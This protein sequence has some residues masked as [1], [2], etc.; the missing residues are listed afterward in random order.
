[1]TTIIVPDKERYHRLFYPPQVED[2]D[3]LLYDESTNTASNPVMGSYFVRT[4]PEDWTRLGSPGNKLIGRHVRLTGADQTEQAQSLDFSF[5][6]SLSPELAWQSFGRP[7]W[8]GNKDTQTDPRP[9]SLGSRYLLWMN[10]A[11]G[12]TGGQKITGDANGLAAGLATQAATGW[13]AS[14][15]AV[16]GFTFLRSTFTTGIM[17]AIRGVA[18]TSL[19]SGGLV[20]A[21][22][23]GGGIILTYLATTIIAG[24]FDN[25][26]WPAKLNAV[27]GWLASNQNTMT[28]NRRAL[29]IKATKIYNPG[30]SL[31]AVQEAELGDIPDGSVDA[32]ADTWTDTQR[33]AIIK[34]LFAWLAWSGDD[35]P[36]VLSERLTYAENNPD[37]FP[38]PAV[39]GELPSVEPIEGTATVLP[40]AITFGQRD[41]AGAS[42]GYE[43][44]L[45]Q[46]KVRVYFRSDAV[47]PGSVNTFAAWTRLGNFTMHVGS[48]HDSGG[49][50]TYGFQGTTLFFAR[51]AFSNLL[52]EGDDPIPPEIENGLVVFRQPQQH[53]PHGVAFLAIQVQGDWANRTA[54]RLTFRERGGQ[55]RQLIQLFY[56]F[57]GA[58]NRV[59]HAGKTYQLY[60]QI[61]PNVSLI[62]QFAKPWWASPTLLVDVTI[63]GTSFASPEDLTIQW[64]DLTDFFRLYDAGDNLL[65]FTSAIAGIR[66][67]GNDPVW[68]VVLDAPDDVTPKRL[69]LRGGFL[70][71]QTDYLR[72]KR[73]GFQDLEIPYPTLRGTGRIPL[74]EPVW[75]KSGSPLRT[76]AALKARADI[77]L[78]GKYAFPKPHIKESMVNMLSLTPQQQKNVL[79]LSVMEKVWIDAVFRPQ[80]GRVNYGKHQVVITGIEHDASRTPTLRWNIKFRYAHQGNFRGRN[81]PAQHP[82][83]TLND[84]VLSRVDGSNW[85]Q[86]A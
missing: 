52:Q 67:D 30:Y 53:D 58:G 42:Y 74:D 50:V 78:L 71:G 49:L 85:L 35:D 80:E 59:T 1:M 66:E 69:T 70:A 39:T 40:T 3:P 19:V 21:A 6:Y 36:D 20:G 37:V 73:L 45:A 17:S 34:C 15:L 61:P 63:D 68:Q 18:L 11:A 14:A 47:L 62:A 44:D 25:E 55:G 51:E 77:E 56:P 83:W 41:L 12:F 23:A 48:H 24:L 81:A 8:W 75:R 84:P 31:G 57:I 43:N 65:S 10:I 9:E 5:D 27:G 82:T 22:V 46:G 32:S 60:S 7:M 54:L 29:L 86:S 38:L 16:K 33:L 4:I 72:T 64:N 2:F 28:P 13:F 76:P 79:S 26:K